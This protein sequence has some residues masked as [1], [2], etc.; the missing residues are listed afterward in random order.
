LDSDDHGNQD[1]SDY[2]KKTTEIEGYRNDGIHCHPTRKREAENYLCQ[3][4]IKAQKGIDIQFTDY[5]DVKVIGSQSTL[6]AKVKV[7]KY[8]IYK[9]ENGENRRELLEVA[10]AL[11]A[12]A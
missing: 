5:C 2:L 11:I 1:N 10:K 8:D 12:L 9:N 4:V 6:I 7:L 3:D